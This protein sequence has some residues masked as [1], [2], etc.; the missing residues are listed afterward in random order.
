MSSPEQRRDE[1]ILADP[2]DNR[3]L[4]KETPAEYIVRQTVKLLIFEADCA[5][6]ILEDK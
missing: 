6:V 4:F 2:E 3:S 5:T 1:E